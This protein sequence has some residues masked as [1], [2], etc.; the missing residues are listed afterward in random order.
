M[1]LLEIAENKKVVVKKRLTNSYKMNSRWKNYFI[2]LVLNDAVPV[3][4]DGRLI[5]VYIVCI[6]PMAFCRMTLVVL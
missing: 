4:E 2:V 5:W 6:C 3:L 1:F